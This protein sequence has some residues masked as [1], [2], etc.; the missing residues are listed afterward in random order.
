MHIGFTAGTPVG[1]VVKRS[2]NYESFDELVT[3]ILAD[4]NIPLNRQNALQY[5]VDIGMIARRHYSGIE[6]ILSKAKQQRSKEG[7]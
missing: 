1:A 5:L 4:S 6:Q 3:T 2:S 7:K